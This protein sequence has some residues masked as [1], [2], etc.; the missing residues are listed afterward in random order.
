MAATLTDRDSLERAFYRLVNTDATDDA[1]TE[2]D[3]GETL[4]AV[5]QAL[6]SGVWDA[7][8]WLIHS[9]LRGRWLTAS[10][11]SVSRVSPLMLRIDTFQ[12]QHANSLLPTPQGTSNILVIWQQGLPPV[13][14][15]LF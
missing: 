12:L 7:Q 5:Y 14:W 8:E 1:L 15:L 10:P 11:P 9:G 13:I 2:H 6:Q 3:D 4:E